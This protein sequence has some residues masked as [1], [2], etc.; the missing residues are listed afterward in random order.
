MICVEL[1]RLWALGMLAKYW[2]CLVFIFH[3]DTLLMKLGV[4]FI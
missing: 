3:V 1:G 4:L 2:E